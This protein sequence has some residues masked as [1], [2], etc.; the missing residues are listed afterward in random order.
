MGVEKLQQLIREHINFA[1]YFEEK[2]LSQKN[3]N[4]QIVCPRTV[5]LVCFRAVIANLSLDEQNQFNEKLLKTLNESGEFYLTHTKVR[6]AYTLRFV[7]GQ[8]L[9]EKRHVDEL[10]DRLAQVVA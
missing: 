4:W 6:G 3:I 10:L 7:S 9:T 1:I 2:L 8:R 5:N